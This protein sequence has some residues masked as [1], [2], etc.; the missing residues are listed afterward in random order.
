MIYFDHCNVI[1]IKDWL[2]S[3]ICSSK[4]TQASSGKE[5]SAHT[6]RHCSFF[7]STFSST[8]ISPYEVTIFVVCDTLQ[9]VVNLWYRHKMANSANSGSSTMLATSAI[10]GR[11]VSTHQTVSICEYIIY[12]LNS[13]LIDPI[14][15]LFRSST[16]QHHMSTTPN[17]SVPASPTMLKVPDE[18]NIPEEN[19]NDV[20]DDELAI[21]GDESDG[22]QKKQSDKKHHHKQ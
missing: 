20:N 14:V 18:E 2:I 10:A 12:F 19:E 15:R 6:A 22:I 4:C 3:F 13:C 21:G 5:E 11:R 7:K 1:Q 9:M 17:N 16:D 8:I